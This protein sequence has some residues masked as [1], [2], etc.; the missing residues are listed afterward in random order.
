MT[1]VKDYMTNEN[2]IKEF[3][4]EEN[5]FNNI[6]VLDEKQENL[7]ETMDDSVVLLTDMKNGVLGYHSRFIK[8]CADK[9]SQWIVVLFNDDGVVYKHLYSALAETGVRFEILIPEKENCAV[10][11]KIKKATRIDRKKIFVW[12]FYPERGKKTIAELL[13]RFLPADYSFDISEGG[14]LAEKIKNSD[15]GSVIIV[16]KN[17]DE[18]RIPVPEGIQ[19]IYIKTYADSNVQLYLRKDRISF[20][21]LKLLPPHLNWTK[22]KAAE[23]IFFISPIYEMWRCNSVNPRLDSGFVMWDE[24]GLPVLLKETKDEDIM[25]FLSQFN[26][27]EKIAKKIKS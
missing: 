11:E 14:V 13:G 17:N 1:I 4:K 19:P 10:Y 7:I 21:I 24:F 16:G 3:I 5:I 9:V 23:Q 18:F 20:E 6:I 12:S 27:A 26:D 22:E 25:E 2:V 15:A 8:S